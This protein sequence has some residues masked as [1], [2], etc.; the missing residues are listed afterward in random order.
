[1]FDVH[2]SHSLQSLKDTPHK[3]LVHLQR[4]RQPEPVGDK[5]SGDKP[6]DRPGID[7]HLGW[8]PECML[9]Y[10]H[11]MHALLLPQREREGILGLNISFLNSLLVSHNPAYPAITP[12]T[13]STFPHLINLCPDVPLGTRSDSLLGVLVQAV[14]PY[15]C[16]LVV[17]VVKVHTL[18][19]TGMK[20]TTRY[21]VRDAV[22]TVH[23]ALTN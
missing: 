18:M 7:L 4:G 14:I 20:A 2:C 10:C 6:G 21:S 13:L 12:H 23:R 16:T 22:G 15:N 17:I 1:M 5:R 19:I 8:Q 3:L 9:C 11:R